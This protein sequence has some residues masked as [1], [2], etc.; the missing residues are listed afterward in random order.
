MQTHIHMCVCLLK[1]CAPSSGVGG[2]VPVCEAA[3]SGEDV[4]LEKDGANDEYEDDDHDLL[5]SALSAASMVLSGPS[6]FTS[7]PLP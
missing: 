2:R 7:L 4:K 6:S 1:R 5:P 3:R